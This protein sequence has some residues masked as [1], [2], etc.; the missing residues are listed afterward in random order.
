M[1]VSGVRNAVCVSG[2]DGGKGR[3]KEKLLQLLSVTG[4]AGDRHCPRLSTDAGIQH[5]PAS[6]VISMA[7]GAAVTVTVVTVI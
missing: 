6:R 2:E 3:Q 1:S 4:Q 5:N 7:A